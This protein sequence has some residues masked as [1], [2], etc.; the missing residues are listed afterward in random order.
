MDTSLI[1]W[2]SQPKTISVEKGQLKFFAKAT[3][4]KSREYWDE[5]VANS[6]GHPALLAPPTFLFNLDLLAPVKEK[7]VLQKITHDVHKKQKN[8]YIRLLNS[9]I[10]LSQYL[11]TIIS[12]L[13][14]ICNV[15]F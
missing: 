3:G 12:K 11:C 7:S 14:L 8:Y 1:G 2:E 10:I 9:L 13:A 5:D 4:A 6:Q 15:L